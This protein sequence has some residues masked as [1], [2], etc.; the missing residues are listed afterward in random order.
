VNSR[1]AAKSITAANSHSAN[2]ATAK[3]GEF[4]APQKV[5]SA[6]KPISYVGTWFLQPICRGMI[7]DR[8]AE[9]RTGH[10]WEATPVGS[11]AGMAVFVALSER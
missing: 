8:L 10:R 2:P 6:V 1:V 5:H 11:L 3:L 4:L 7:E 9:R